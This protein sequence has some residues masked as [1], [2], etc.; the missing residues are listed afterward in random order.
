MT[1]HKTGTREEWLAAGG[2]KKGKFTYAKAS[3]P[4]R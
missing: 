1:D 3:P 2:L 4:R